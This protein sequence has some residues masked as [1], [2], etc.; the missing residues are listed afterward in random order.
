MPTIG[1]TPDWSRSEGK[2]SRYELNRA[3]CDAVLVGGGLP[4][5]LAYSDDPKVLAAYLETI[6][7][8]L[9]TGGAFDIDPETYGERRRPSCGPAKPERTAFER[10][11]LAETLKRDLPVLGV[12]GGMQL[13]N[14][15]LGGSL[16]QDLPT[17][18]PSAGA[19]EQKSDKRQPSHPVN[20][21]RGTRLARAVGEGQ[22]MVN[23]THHQGVRHLGEGVSATALSPDDLTEGIEVSGYRWV[24]GVQWHP[25]LLLLTVPANLGLYRSFVKATA[26]ARP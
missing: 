12:C 11:L 3:Y 26:R 23:S 20:V 21:R 24:V 16:F 15:T 18:M 8:L 17:E 25:E 22:L 5:V 14:V 9:L 13:I 6:D 4:L 7:G 2:P 19:H 1:V 10:A